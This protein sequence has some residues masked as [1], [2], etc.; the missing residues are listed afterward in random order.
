MVPP[1]SLKCGEF[2]GRAVLDPFGTGAARADGSREP[3]S[4]KW[5]FILRK[6]GRRPHGIGP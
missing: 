6:I 1:L 4:E 3:L 5:T 2:E